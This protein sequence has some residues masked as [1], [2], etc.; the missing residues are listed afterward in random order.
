MSGYSEGWGRVLSPDICLRLGTVWSFDDRASYFDLLLSIGRNGQLRTSL[1]DQ[2][3]DFN[4]HI[5]NFPFPRSIIPS[6]PAYGVFMPPHQ[7]IGGILF[8]SCLSVSLFVCLFIYL[9]VCLLSTLTFAITFEPYKRKRLQIWYA[10]ST[11]DALSNETKVND[12]VTLTLT[13]KQKIAFSTLLP[14]GA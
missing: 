13:L 11:N 14:P 2:C 4:L 6:S 5:T 10:Y 1:Y 7:M 12:L 8:L 9:S 3:G